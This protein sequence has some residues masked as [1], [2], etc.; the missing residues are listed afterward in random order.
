MRNYMWTLIAVGFEVQW[1]AK[2]KQSVL[3]AGLVADFHIS[4]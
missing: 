4:N 3:T 2:E 1:N